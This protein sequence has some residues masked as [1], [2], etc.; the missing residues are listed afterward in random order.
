M[1]KKN[2]FLLGLMSVSILFTVAITACN[3][4]DYDCA[5]GYLKCEKG[6]CCEEDVPW[7]D[8]HGTCYS[9]ASYCHSGGYNCTKCW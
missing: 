7:T 9:S 8:G 5:D 6:G 3:L 1:K 4:Y 2:I